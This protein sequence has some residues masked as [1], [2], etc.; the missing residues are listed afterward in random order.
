MNDPS[1]HRPDDDAHQLGMLLRNA[2]FALRRC[3]NAQCAELGA[4]GDQ[5]VLLIP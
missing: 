1:P 3:S 5:F 2:Y 4:N